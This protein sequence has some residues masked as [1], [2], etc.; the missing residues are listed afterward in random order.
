MFPLHRLQQNLNKALLHL[1][2]TNWF[3]HIFQP[4]QNQSSSNFPT[5]ILSG[6]GRTRNQTNKIDHQDFHP[7]PTTTDGRTACEKSIPVFPAL[8]QC[9]N[10]FSKKI[11]QTEFRSGITWVMIGIKIPIHPHRPDQY[12]PRFPFQILLTGSKQTL[13][14]TEKKTGLKW[15]PDAEFL[16]ESTNKFYLLPT[17]P[18]WWSYN[19]KTIQ[20]P[21]PHK[22]HQL[23]E[24]QCNQHVRPEESP[25]YSK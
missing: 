8:D 23:L 5:Q 21:A 2:N 22:T 11:H 9:S 4:A 18:N 20:S 14:P 6:S 13:P 25:L 19:R 1:L 17:A 24:C 16:S 7:I 10:C 15:Q 3:N 12:L